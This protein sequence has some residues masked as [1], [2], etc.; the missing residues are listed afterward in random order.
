MSCGPYRGLW[1]E[2]GAHETA[3]S[4]QHAPV[5]PQ[6]DAAIREGVIYTQAHPYGVPP[7]HAVVSMPAVGPP[8]GHSEAFYAQY[9]I[10]ESLPF[11][12]IGV[13]WFLAILGVFFPVAWILA[14]IIFCTNGV[15]DPRERTGLMV[16]TIVAVIC[17]PLWIMELSRMLSQHGH[18]HHHRH[19]MLS[20]F[21][22]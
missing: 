16:A 1:Q 18:D 17:T 13:G 9:D 12:G 6:R 3:G 20:W 10:N 21:H 7:D 14:A 15:R 2:E 22:W 11:C 5:G 19:H 4:R 8:A